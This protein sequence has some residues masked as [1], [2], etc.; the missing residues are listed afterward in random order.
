MNKQ[1]KLLNVAILCALAVSSANIA[2]AQDMESAPPGLNSAPIDSA[3][4]AYAT[5]LLAEQGIGVVYFGSQE[6]QREIG[7]ESRSTADLDSGFTKNVVVVESGWG[8]RDQIMKLMANGHFI[9]TI[10]NANVDL[11]RSAFAMVYDIN[12]T[13]SLTQ[14]E[15]DYDTSHALRLDIADGTPGYSMVEAYLFTTNGSRSFHT[16][17]QDKSAALAKAIQWAR[18]IAMTGGAPKPG[19]VAKAGTWFPAHTRDVSHVCYKTF[20]DSP[21]Q[22]KS[23]TLNI[24]TSFSKVS[25]T[26]TQYDA[27]EIRY[28]TQ[29][30]PNTSRRWRN[31]GMTI[32]SDLNGVVPS[33]HLMSYG[34]TTSPGS[35]TAS[36]DLSASLGSVSFG[37][38][39][40]YSRSDIEIFDFSDFSRH[41][42]KWDHSIDKTKAVGRNNV[43]LEPGA[44]LRV[45][46]GRVRPWNSLNETYQA[47]FHRMGPFGI[48]TELT[49]ECIRKINH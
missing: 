5:Q 40:S 2:T 16:S 19:P 39:W 1:K 8:N 33:F 24:R 36:V 46:H 4:V 45:G 30:V 34:P 27:Y 41:L 14:S 21:L 42:V 20:S 37:R 22:L 13:G 44:I 32:Q 15:A 17:E 38:S 35:S 18:D 23:G 25:E 49:H 47:T 26:N 28:T 43:L 31:R 7:L 9:I 6:L 11:V 29:M 10:G 12:E 3:S 48:S